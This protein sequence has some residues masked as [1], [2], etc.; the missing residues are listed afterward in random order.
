M[1]NSRKVPHVP[2]NSTARVACSAHWVAVGKGTSCRAIGPGMFLCSRMP[3]HRSI[4][5]L[6]LLVPGLL[7]AQK[8]DTIHLFNGDKVVGEMK[9]LKLGLLRVKTDYMA[10]V[11]IEWDQVKT[12]RTDKR[13]YIRLRNGAYFDGSLAA[14]PQMDHLYV[15]TN[16]DSIHV[17]LIDI[18]PP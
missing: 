13:W 10:T 1:P 17:N 15:L 16:G 9:D 8:T 2:C 11:Y 3:S 7:A 4:A 5:F 14:S 6:L 12:V 18:T